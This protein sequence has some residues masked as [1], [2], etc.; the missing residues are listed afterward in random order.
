MA[1]DQGTVRDWKHAGVE[2]RLARRGL[3]MSQQ[4]LAERIG[5]DRRTIGNYEAGRAPAGDRIP[6]GYYDVARVVGWAR[7][8]IE[9]ILAGGSPTPVGAATEARATAPLLAPGGPLPADLYPG[10][11]AF[12]R[13]CVRAGGDAALRDL[14]EEAAERLLRSVP[15]RE[16]S[17]QSYGLA[18]Y[19][20]HGW[21]EGDPGVP[22]DD[23]ARIRQALEAFEQGKKQA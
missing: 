20:P 12:G 15:Q 23:A 2:I 13:A 11:I 10:V 19:R 4:D 8:S 6:D 9:D 3:G 16:A 14:V 7:Q 17:A 18:A 5:V 21:A 1:A 22:D